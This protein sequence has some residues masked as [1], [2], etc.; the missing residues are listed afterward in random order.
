MLESL[1]SESTQVIRG[2]VLDPDSLRPAMEGVDCAYYLVHSMAGDKPFEKLDR[3]AAHCFAAT[4]AE[5]GV[6]RIIYLG[7]LAGGEGLSGH[8]RSRIEVGEILRA[9]SVLTLEF[10]ASVIIGAG[11]LSFEVIRSLVNRLP[12]M[13]TPRWVSTRCQPI[14]ISD[15]LFY[16]KAA[17]EL[18]IEGSCVF[19]I[20]GAD[21]ASYMDIM[22]EYGRQRGLRRFFLPV[23]VLTPWLSSLWLGLVTPVLARVGRQLIE[24]VRNESVVV[25]AKA[26]EAFPIEPV[27]MREAIAEA[28]QEES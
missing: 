13:V 6:R 18:E 11:S 5:A 16:L 19:E 2:D 12:V 10:R 14:A 21:T 3:E 25:D 23:P 9:S 26:L 28:L 15:V 24:G 1:E 22:K 8:L 17:L 27:T 20:G 4:A 7:G